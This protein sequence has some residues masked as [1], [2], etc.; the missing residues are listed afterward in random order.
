MTDEFEENGLLFRCKI[1]TEQST[2]NND[3]FGNRFKALIK[4]PTP[5][6]EQILETA[7]SEYPEFNFALAEIKAEHTKKVDSEGG[8]LETVYTAMIEGIEYEILTRNGSLET[9]F[10]NEEITKMLKELKARET[11]TFCSD[12]KIT[13]RLEYKDLGDGLNYY[14]TPVNSYEFYAML[15]NMQDNSMIKL[16]KLWTSVCN[17]LGIKSDIPLSENRLKEIMPET[18]KYA[19]EKMPELIANMKQ[20]A[21]YINEWY[22]KIG[23][24]SVSQNIRRDVANM[25]ISLEAYHTIADQ[26]E[27]IEKK[28]TKLCRQ[29]KK[30]KKPK[31]K[32]LK[33]I[34][35]IMVESKKLF[36]ASTMSR[37]HLKNYL[38]IKTY[39]LLS[40]VKAEKA[41]YQ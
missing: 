40:S 24:E 4:N 33:T 21:D 6:L 26:Y 2:E 38:V 8:F 23:K 18:L 25:R 15:Y 14:A 30:A 5:E 20:Y 10:F 17:S 9:V 16:N 12:T 3:I 7:N 29:I 19:N 22:D 39:A 13:L 36:I 31:K 35:E 1:G 32:Q 11:K 41:R 27:A 28:Y 34:D 37:T